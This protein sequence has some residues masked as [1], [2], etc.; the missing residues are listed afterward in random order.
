MNAWKLHMASWAGIGYEKKAGMM[1]MHKQ[2]DRY[3]DS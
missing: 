1:D 2:Y 3:M